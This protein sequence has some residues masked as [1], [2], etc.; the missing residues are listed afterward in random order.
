MALS[1]H[2]I[3]AASAARATA[4]EPAR[5]QAGGLED[6]IFAVSINCIVRTG[7]FMPTAHAYGR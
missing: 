5:C 2:R 4:Q 6:R 1:G 7:R 3:I